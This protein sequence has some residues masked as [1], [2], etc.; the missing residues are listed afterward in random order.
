MNTLT[1]QRPNHAVISILLIVLLCLSVLA[2]CV[3]NDPQQGMPGHMV[4]TIGAV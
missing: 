3:E 1:F 2:S 4:Q